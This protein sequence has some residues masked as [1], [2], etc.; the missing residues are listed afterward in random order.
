MTVEDSWGG[1]VTTSAIAHLAHSTAKAMRFSS[2]DF[3]S[4]VSVDIASGA[5]KR[6][7]GRM[8][9]SINPGL[10]IEPYEEIL[11]KPLIEIN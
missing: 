3:N 11:G 5:P 1:D 10:G 8:S 9:A 2:T 4:Y 6:M 7:N